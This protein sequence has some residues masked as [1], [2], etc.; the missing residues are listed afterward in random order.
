MICGINNHIGG[1]IKSPR[2]R[3]GA[4]VGSICRIHR[5]TSPIQL[6]KQVRCAVPANRGDSLGYE[7]P[8]QRRVEH[9]SR[10]Y[11]QRS[12]YQQRPEW[13]I[14]AHGRLLFVVSCHI[15]IS[16]VIHPFLASIICF[17]CR[18]GTIVAGVKI[19]IS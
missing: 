6:T 8:A 9:D 15:F 18:I 5:I 3:S 11:Q 7:K 19:V 4:I 16:R 14:S 10:Q 13:I 17:D 12:G 1:I 2:V